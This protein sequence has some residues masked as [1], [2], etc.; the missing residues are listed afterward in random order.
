MD[1]AMIMWSV[2]F[3]AIGMG[4]FVFGKRQRAIVPSCIGMALIIFP[5]FVAS[6]TSLLIIGVILIAIPYFIRI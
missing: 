5:Y 2:L 4:Y 3:G 1:A 6:V